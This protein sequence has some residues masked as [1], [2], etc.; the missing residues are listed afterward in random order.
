MH[1][2]NPTKI[3]HFLQFFPPFLKKNTLKNREK[4][5]FLCVG[6]GS[7]PLLM[8]ELRMVALRLFLIAAA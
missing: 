5:F 8:K 3:N 1:N 6:G 4:M 2:F 7:Q